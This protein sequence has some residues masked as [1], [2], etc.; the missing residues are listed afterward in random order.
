MPVLINC[1]HLLNDDFFKKYESLE[2][3]QNLNKKEKSII[4]ENIKT[5]RIIYTDKELDITIIEIKNEDE[6][7]IYSFL[8]IDTPILN[9]DTNLV[10]G[11]HKG[12]LDDCGIHFGKG[13][14]I[15]KAIKKFIEK[16]MKEK[17]N[18]INDGSYKEYKD[19]YSSIDIIYSCPPNKPIQLFDQEFVI[20]NKDIC[21]I[22]YGQN[23]NF[24]DIYQYMPYSQLSLEDRTK[25]EFTIQLIGINKVTNMMHMFRKCKNLEKLP[26]ISKIDTSRVINM[27]AMFEECNNL[28]FPD[29]SSWNVEN[30]EI[31]RGFFYSCWNLKFLPGIE[32]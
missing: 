30:V 21:K 6:L 26:N 25:G 9:Y 27:R 32:R 4:L 11:V 1:Y 12:G 22:K 19:L 28:E 10:I 20:N 16:K 2:L 14:I 3:I 23:D 31:M 13:I 18:N 8:E 5:N 15:K 24:M 7:N 17:I 29:L